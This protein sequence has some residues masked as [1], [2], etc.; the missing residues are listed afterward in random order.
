VNK[1]WQWFDGKK[2]TIGGMISTFVS[3]AYT[4]DLGVPDRV[5]AWLAV[6]GM[7]VFGGGAVHK[8]Q[9]GGK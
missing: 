7:V 6:L 2:T 5:L 9:K 4:F 3:C 1:I 8:A